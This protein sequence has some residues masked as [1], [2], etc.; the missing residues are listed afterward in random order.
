MYIQTE[1][2]AYNKNRRDV[3]IYSKRLCKIYKYFIPFAKNFM[4]FSTLPSSQ[5]IYHEHLRNHSVLVPFLFPFPFFVIFRDLFV[6]RRIF[7]TQKTRMMRYYYST[8]FANLHRVIACIYFI[9][10][11]SK[12]TDIFQ[13][14]LLDNI[15]KKVYTK[16][17]CPCKFFEIKRN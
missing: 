12:I 3:N 14:K 17:I 10:T 7:C 11:E 1:R 4:N 16:Q 13:R 9:Q 8:Y 6:V 2:G 5:S 15:K